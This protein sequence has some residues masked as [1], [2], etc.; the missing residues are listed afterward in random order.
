MLMFNYTGHLICLGTVISLNTFYVNVQQQYKGEI[1][2]EK[3]GLNTFYVNVQHIKKRIKK[4]LY[5]V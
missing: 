3:M 5:S 4:L 1:K 2:M